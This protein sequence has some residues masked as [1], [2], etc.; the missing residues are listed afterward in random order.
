MVI[1][2]GKKIPNPS[3]SFHQSCRI[4]CAEQMQSCIS[5]LPQQR[6][7][8]FLIIHQQYPLLD[9]TFNLVITACK[10]QTFKCN[11][12]VKYIYQWTYTFGEERI[13]TS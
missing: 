2:L 13:N 12:P 6:D 10:K 7:V 11:K 4:P 1:L 8:K 9:F 3:L 5:P